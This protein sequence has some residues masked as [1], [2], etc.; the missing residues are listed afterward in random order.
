MAGGINGVI[1]MNSPFYRF[2]LI[3]SLF[4]IAVSIILNFVLI[5][6]YGITGAAIATTSSLF[7]YNIA[8][9]IFVY[10]KYRIQPLS[11]KVIPVILSS[12][13]IMFISFQ[14]DTL[15]GTY[16]DI[17]IRSILILVLYSFLMVYFK[18]SPEVL[19][20]WSKANRM[21]KIR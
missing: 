2:N 12:V 8:K 4:L 15:V 3:A 5:P 7:F 14:I 19:K 17:A 20:Y 16:F 1:I 10:I 13:S 9:S 18:V 6:S 21:V 11:Y